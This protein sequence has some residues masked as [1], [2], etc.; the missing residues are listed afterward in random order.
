MS[1]VVEI[2]TQRDLRDY[3]AGEADAETA[4]R[5]RAACEE[6]PRVADRVARLEADF[7]TRPVSVRDAAE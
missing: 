6:D 2:L 3:A 7:A 5:V 1:C 4:V